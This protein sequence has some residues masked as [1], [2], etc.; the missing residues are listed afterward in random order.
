MDF[1]WHDYEG[2][3][4]NTVIGENAEL[5]VNDFK[6]YLLV[7]PNNR[8]DNIEDLTRLLQTMDDNM[9]DR[10]MIYSKD[11]AEFLK[12]KSLEKLE[13]VKELLLKQ[14]LQ[15]SDYIEGDYKIDIELDDFSNEFKIGDITT[16][17]LREK[18]LGHEHRERIIKDYTI[19]D[20]LSRIK[21]EHLKV[22]NTDEEIIITLE[23]PPD[24]ENEKGGKIEHFKGSGKI[25]LE[26]IVEET[27]GKV[28]S[29]L[30]DNEGERK[31]LLYELE[32]IN[33]KATKKTKNI[34]KF[35]DNIIDL[36]LNS[37]ENFFGKA[38]IP[39]ILKSRQI[40]EV[41][42]VL[43]LRVYENP[44]DEQF[45]EYVKEQASIKK[46]VRDM[47]FKIRFNTKAIPKNIILKENEEIIGSDLR[48]I[49]PKSKVNLHKDNYFKFIDAKI[50]ELEYAIK[51]IPEGI[52]TKE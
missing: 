50:E 1:I 28:G 35:K 21:K 16:D 15:G 27:D 41:I 3:K 44:T 10:G 31:T 26:E 9:E 33:K 19:E 12:E 49:R 20:F 7:Y 46:G 29:F 17:S 42:I 8:R 11:H 45:K 47:S 30:F 37:K 34:G 39:A 51:R 38:I 5:I 22:D 2:H 23:L 25:K 36:I 13:E 48:R 14:E 43:T 4:A 18:E 24:E 6:R 32:K 52:E 40:N